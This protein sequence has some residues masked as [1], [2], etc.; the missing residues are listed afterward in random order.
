ML[1]S[2]NSDLKIGIKNDDINILNIIEKFKKNGIKIIEDLS[3]NELSLVIREANKAYYTNNPL[4]TDN[5]FDII[6]DFFGEKYPDNNILMEIGTQVLQNKVKLPYYMGSMDKI[7]PDTKALDIW[8]KKYTGPYLLSAKLDGISALYVN[9]NGI[10]N[11]YKRGDGIMAQDISY[12]IPYLDLP[13]VK[14]IV[15]R[16]E[17]IML[18]K[19]FDLKYKNNILCKSSR[20]M[21][22]GLT[23]KK[24][25]D[26]R[27][28]DID[29]VAHELI[30]PIKTPFEQFKYMDSLSVKTVITKFE[31]NISNELLSELLVDWRSNYKYDIDGII[32]SDNKIYERKQKNPE[33]SFAFKMILSDQIAEAKVVDV[34][35]TPSKY[36]YL[37]PRVRIE[38]I[39]LGGVKIEYITGNNA[40][41]IEENKIGIGALIKII[42][43]GD[44]IP[45]IISITE[46]SEFPKMPDVPYK[47][48]NS[49]V[50]AIINNIDIDK[51]VIEKNITS[52]FKEIKVDGIGSGNINRII[53]AG[54]ITISEILNMNIEDFLKVEGFKIKMAEKLYYGIKEAINNSSLITI[55]SASGCFGRGF[56][57]KKIELIINEYPDILISNESQIEKIN[58]VKNIKGLA[59]KT[60]ILFVENIPD[61]IEFVEICNLT[62][63]L[64]NIIVSK[65]EEINTSHELY[66]KN[67]VLTGFRDK[68]LMDYLKNIGAIIGSK[69][70][71]NT[72]A[73][74]VKDLNESSV[75][76][77]DAKKLNIP[78]Y[79]FEDF[80]KKYFKK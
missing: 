63:K 39:Y 8:L 18:K 38:P 71:K 61:F 4:M 5:N 78:I 26:E 14:D 53:D 25:V 32:V 52:F 64:D 56:S 40:S 23:N 76:I 9:E 69:V 66:S 65:K 36:G 45:K 30:K 21:V 20:H 54:F 60:A 13:N 79:L 43:S 50:D 19:V 57:N 55:M 49:H 41:Y 15:I 42:R 7:K 44:V 1:K 3:E 59:E 2:S 6:K 10:K 22:S 68:N 11:L 77:N 27:M 16:G 62:Y 29:F 28:K 74:I 73:V 80:T 24:K 34:I 72:F 46:P 12:L 47:W 51:T 48:T 35:W 17:L 33:Q 75:K 70:N 58:K 67:I 31:K 37:K